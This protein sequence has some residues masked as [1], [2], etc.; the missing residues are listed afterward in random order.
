LAAIGHGF[1]II[2]E[3]KMES[4]VGSGSVIPGNSQGKRGFWVLTGSFEFTIV[5]ASMLYANCTE[6]D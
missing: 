3:V 6:C 5:L 2:K 1:N 4:I